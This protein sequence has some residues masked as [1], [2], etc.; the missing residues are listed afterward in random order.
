MILLGMATLLPLQS[1]WSYMLSCILRTPKVISPL[2]FLL[3]RLSQNK[4]FSLYPNSNPIS[5]IEWE[6]LVHT[7]PF[8]V[9]SL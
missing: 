7:S 1:S 9:L 3:G 6:R 2:F 5:T 4:S 8:V